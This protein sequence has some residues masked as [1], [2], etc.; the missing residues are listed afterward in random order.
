MMLYEQI[1]SSVIDTATKTSYSV[2]QTA[3][4]LKKYIVPEYR[5]IIELIQ[6]EYRTIY[7]QTTLRAFFDAQFGKDLT[8]LILMKLPLKEIKQIYRLNKTI[9]KYIDLSFWMQVY[10][11][12]YPD[13]YVRI[14]EMLK[15]KNGSQSR[16]LTETESTG[17]PALVEDS[18]GL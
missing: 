15:L 6:H 7:T 1:R 8:R 14:K 12:K 17:L 3:N 4:I 16:L 18:L 10:T 2:L 9:Y 11:F 5:Y 13:V